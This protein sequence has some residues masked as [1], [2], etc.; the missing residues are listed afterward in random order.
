M[1]QLIHIGYRSEPAS[2]YQ[3]VIA[4]VIV[5]NALPD[6]EVILVDDDQLDSPG[7]LNTFSLSEILPEFNKN[8]SRITF[9]KKGLLNHLAIFRK[10]IS[11]RLA[12]ESKLRVGS[13][14]GNLVSSA[15]DFLY[16]VL[17]VS[18]EHQFKM[19]PVEIDPQS[20]YFEMPADELNESAETS[21]ES[22]L[23]KVI[24]K[25]QT[26]FLSKLDQV[27]SSSTLD[28]IILD[29]NHAAILSASDLDE[30]FKWMLLPL[31]EYPPLPGQG[32]TVLLSNDPGSQESIVE[33]IILRNN[34]EK[35]Y[36]LRKTLNDGKE[37]GVF[38]V[39]SAQKSFVYASSLNGTRR[40]S[41]WKFEAPA[42]VSKIFS[43]TDFM[44]GFFSY[45]NFEE[46]VNLDKFE[47]LFIASHK[48][49][50]N[51]QLL[52]QLKKKRVWAAG[53]RTWS[54]LAKLGIWVE[55]CADALGLENALPI[56]ESCPMPVQKQQVCILTNK[57]S[58]VHWIRDGWNAIG[59]YELVPAKSEAIYE[60]IKEADFLFWTSFQQYEVC[61]SLVKPGAIHASAAGKTA[62]LLKEQGCNPVVFP[63]IKAFEYWRKGQETN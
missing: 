62:S 29:P 33:D 51:T 50:H 2:M 17:P 32:Y 58:T 13:V 46:A 55:G 14:K 31:F 4:K 7:V 20:F 11:A 57:S 36:E 35:E 52:E 8:S 5:T 26:K 15:T 53:A 23:E 22:S 21:L 39:N 41:K 30:K 54:E 45:Q 28:G 9:I 47:I 3:A 61:K 60:I 18:R 59:T 44:K 38:S 12:C 25:I 6:S 34:F 10:D 42:S 56:M 37:T 40:A 43:G 16:K 49:V 19:E 63:T 1:S 48:A 27:L 24:R